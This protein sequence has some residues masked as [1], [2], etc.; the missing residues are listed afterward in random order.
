MSFCSEINLIVVFFLHLVGP[1]AYRRHD[2]RGTSTEEPC[3]IRKALIFTLRNPW[4]RLSQALLATNLCHFRF[5][6]EREAQAFV[7]IPAC[8]HRDAAFGGEPD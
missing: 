3:S 1:P 5:G 4:F 8:R 2:I 7:L 6:R